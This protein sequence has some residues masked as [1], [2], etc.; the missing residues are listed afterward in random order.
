MVTRFVVGRVLTTIPVL[1]AAVAFTFVALRLLPADPAAFLAS[2][3]GMGP[4][5]IAA[6]RAQLGLDH[7]IPTQFVLYLGQVLHLDLGR[8]ITTGQPVLHDL[9]R[10]LPASLEL[11]FGGLL[12]ACVLGLPL[13]IVAAA[14]PRSLIDHF[15]RFVAAL[16]GALPAFVTGLVL[17]Y[18]FYVRLDWA[19][20]PAGQLA[21]LLAPPPARTGFLLIDAALAGTGA[22]FVSALWHLLLPCLTMALFA[23]GPIARITRA[24]MLN[25]LSSDYIR[26]ARALGLPGRALLH[27]AFANAALPIV[28]ALGLTFS[29]MLGANVVVEKVFAWPGLGSYAVDA[30]QG[31]DYAALQGFVLAVA[32]IFACVNVFVD[33]AGGVLDPRARWNT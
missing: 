25:A 28:T 4:D 8:S 21:P 2:G 15:C 14:R 33:V 11:A 30:L 6:L 1:L 32:A 20:E 19:P 17:I 16:G 5:E 27:Y 10:R 7:A 18:V 9:L 23:L 24:A 13:G 12:L 26:S 29:Y 31:A 22:V 3:P